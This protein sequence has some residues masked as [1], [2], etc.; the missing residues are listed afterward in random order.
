MDA[1][2]YSATPFNGYTQGPG[3]YG[4][5]FFIWPPDPRNGSIV[6]TTTLKTYLNALG[7]TN[8]NDQTTLAN[9]WST[10]LGQG[11]TTGLTNLQ[12]WLSGG[13]TSGGPYTT[14]SPYV[15]GSSNKA[16]VYYAVCRLFNRAYPGGTSAGAFSA[17]WRARFFGTTN[18]SLLFNSSGSLN[19]PGGSTYTIN[20]NAI[21]SWLAQSPNPFPSQLRAGRVKFYG[22]IPSSLTGSWPSYG[23]TDQRFWQEIIDHVLGFRQTASGTYKDLSGVGSS[24]TTAGYGTDFTWGTMSVNSA[25]SAP[26]VYELHGQPG[27]RAVA[28]LVQ[29]HPH[30]RLSA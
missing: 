14:S 22:S 8:T 7:V 30:G 3:Y 24:N 12:N 27:P 4:K 5:T 16:P 25:P 18:N 11:T 1:G 15:S 21:L 13:T 20:Y 6:N 9:N 28:L 2:D 29:S 26:A 23:G 19:L 10:W 17:D